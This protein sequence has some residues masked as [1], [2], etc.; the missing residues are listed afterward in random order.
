MS[1]SKQK[2]TQW[3][4]EVVEYL[5]RSG[6]PHAE[7]RSLNGAKDRGDVAGCPGLVVECKNAKTVTLAAWLDEANVERAN[8][9]ADL[10]VV[11]H[12]RRGRASAGE[13]FVT[14]DGRTFVW[15]LRSAGYG[16][17]TEE[18]GER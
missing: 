18:G 8:D 11:W 10:G 3:E 6:F 9:H 15:L 4:R 13:G 17:P 14:L 12:H 1:R 2:G 16:D 5:R 7:R